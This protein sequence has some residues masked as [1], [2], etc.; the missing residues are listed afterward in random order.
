MP[1]SR[2]RYND[3]VQ[4][5]PEA[6][7][8]YD[9]LI[10]QALNNNDPNR[11][12]HDYIG[13]PTTPTTRIDYDPTRYKQTQ[14]AFSR[15]L[16]VSPS[17]DVNALLYADQGGWEMFGKTV[18]NLL[19]NSVLNMVEQVGSAF[20]FLGGKPDYE[21]AVTKW[22]S[23]KKDALGD[24]YRRDPDAVFD[25]GDPSWWL[26]HGK[27]LTS[28]VIAFGLMGAGV[29]TALAKGAMGFSRLIQGMM[30]ADKAARY[31]SGISRTLQG[32]ANLGSASIL[33]YAEGT[34]SGAETYKKVYD[35]E[36]QRTGDAT[37]AEQVAAR[38]AANTVKI[39]TAMNTALNVTSLAPFFKHGS[40]SDLRRKVG[41]QLFDRKNKGIRLD[42]DDA[43]SPK[44]VPVDGAMRTMVLEER[45]ALKRALGK[46]TLTELKDEIASSPGIK[47][48]VMEYLKR[49]GKKA[50]HESIQEALEELN[51]IWSEKLGEEG[52]GLDYMFRSPGEALAEYWELAKSE[53]GRL[54]MFLGA[55]GGAGQTSFIAAMP[56]TSLQK[57][58][59]TG[60]NRLKISAPKEFQ[61]VR[62]EIS[63]FATTKKAIIDDINDLM[64]AEAMLNQGI[65]EDNSAKIEEAKQQFFNIKARQTVKRGQTDLMI[66]MMEE[67]QGLDNSRPMDESTGESEAKILGFA[68]NNRDNEYIAT[69]QRQI[70][71]LTKLDEAYKQTFDLVNKHDKK[72]PGYSNYVLSTLTDFYSYE[73]LANQKLNESFK[74]LEKALNQLGGL[75]QLES[76]DSKGT[77]NPLKEVVDN[78]RKVLGDNINNQG[79]ITLFTKDNNE[80]I[81]DA[82]DKLKRHKA[83]GILQTPEIKAAFD[84]I[85]ES[86]EFARKS[87]IGYDSYRNAISAEGLKEYKENNSIEEYNKEIEDSIEQELISQGY[88]DEVFDEKFW[89]DLE[90]ET[91][92]TQENAKNGE[93]FVIKIGDN[94]VKIKYE[95]QVDEE[96]NPVLDGENNPVVEPKVVSSVISD[97]SLVPEFT[98]V[99]TKSKGFFRAAKNDDVEYLTAN[100]FDRINAEIIVNREL[101]EISELL[102]KNQKMLEERLAEK[103]ELLNKL[104]EINAEIKE[105]KK[106]FE[107]DSNSKS[108]LSKAR[109]LEL[110]NDLRNRIK[111]LRAS[112]R[113]LNKD[114]KLLEDSKDVML[115]SQATLINELL[116]LKKLGTLDSTLFNRGTEIQQRHNKAV[117]LLQESQQLMTET[118]N[119]IDALNDLRIKIEDAIMTLADLVT[120]LDTISDFNLYVKYLINYR[121]SALS[122][123]NTL[124]R[125][126][127]ESKLKAFENAKNSGN[128]NMTAL[129]LANLINTLS[130]HLAKKGGKELDVLLRRQIELINDEF[131]NVRDKFLKSLTPEER[132]V[133]NNVITDAEEANII[134]YLTTAIPFENTITQLEN[135]LQIIKDT[136]GDRKQ[137]YEQTKKELNTFVDVFLHIQRLRNNLVEE[138]EKI[139]DEQSSEDDIDG[140]DLT[141]EK[142]EETFN[143]RSLN[144][145]IFN[146]TGRD[147]FEDAEGN[148]VQ[149]ENFN[150]L[151]YT[152]LDKNAGSIKKGIAEGKFKLQAFTS[153]NLPENIRKI[154]ESDASFQLQDG[155]IIVMPVSK[156][157]DNN[158]Y[159]VK[160]DSEGNF[161]HP[162]KG[163]E[164]SDATVVFNFMPLVESQLGENYEDFRENPKVTDR[165]IIE[166][167]LQTE[168]GRNNFLVSEDNL[169]EITK[170]RL[171]IQDV[172][173]N[174]TDYEVF[175]QRAYG[176]VKTQFEKSLESIK[177]Q[178]DEAEEGQAVL[179]D[180]VGLTKG[181]IKFKKGD[182]GYKK[183][184]EVI[185]EFLPKDAPLKKDGTKNYK[186]VVGRN[187]STN[188]TLKNN[189]FEIPGNNS[190]QSFLLVDGQTEAI[191]V[192][193]TLIDDSEINTLLALIKAAATKPNEK[194]LTFNT[195]LDADGKVKNISTVNRQITPS[196]GAV[197]TLLDSLISWNS[198]NEKY[199][200]YFD[201]GR[202]KLVFTNPHTQSGMVSVPFSEL[203]AMT[204]DAAQGKF[205][206]NEQIDELVRFLKTKRINV[207]SKLLDETG[208]FYA[209][210]IDAEGNIVLREHSDYTTFLKD[211]LM[212]P[213]IFVT[214]KGKSKHS[215]NLNLGITSEGFINTST[216]T[217]KTG[218]KAA[219][220]SS[221][222]SSEKKTNPRQPFY[223][224]QVVRVKVYNRKTKK[225]KFY[226]AIVVSSGGEYTMVKFKKDGKP[227]KFTNQN[228]YR[229]KYDENVYTKEKERKKSTPKEERNK[230]RKSA[231]PYLKDTIIIHEGEEYRAVKPQTDKV[232]FYPKNFRTEPFSYKDLTKEEEQEIKDKSL[233]VFNDEMLSDYGVAPNNP[234][235]DVEKAEKFKKAREAKE[236]AKSKES[237]TSGQLLQD[238]DFTPL[239]EYSEDSVRASILEEY[240][241]SA[242]IGNI[243]ETF[244]EVMKATANPDLDINNKQAVTSE[245][246][247]PE[248]MRGMI[249]SKGLDKISTFFQPY[250]D[251]GFTAAELL[252]L[253]KIKE[254]K[255][256]T[257]YNPVIEKLTNKL[258]EKNPNRETQPTT[259]TE[260]ET[261]TEESFETSTNPLDNLFGASQ[262]VDLGQ[263]T[264][265][266]SKPPINDEDSNNEITDEEDPNNLC[267]TD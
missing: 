58:E 85:A 205:T 96:G 234:N 88:L 169:K 6:F 199:K 104:K 246:S 159:P 223:K 185:K 209:P 62:D 93:E 177:T 90:S 120:G 12:I 179:L 267:I 106:A 2:F 22:A 144:D 142:M 71:I 190:G 152:Y 97:D 164:Y 187:V 233:T 163:K 127:I 41:K 220:P 217:V 73:E 167:F 202:K 178:I 108:K 100:E 160:V 45:D 222:T 225:N 154:I 238:E 59:K 43:V 36:F 130:Y 203:T 265:P 95:P 81:E 10:N 250:K 241:D 109:F 13:L 53:E 91:G 172:N 188:K 34:L 15:G 113:K 24:V 33:A 138:R 162:S 229:N 126:L 261:S 215:R 161:I 21:N 35:R 77:P 116:F 47:N 105:A 226:T 94:A 174:P 49:T 60:R 115:D 150:E 237:A 65:K 8:E 11:S 228:V 52:R 141:P 83:S 231:I 66:A 148:P 212:M 147:L 189:S 253:F 98:T 92:I 76:F 112:Q 211:K 235:Y 204:Y 124:E 249:V 1:R 248:G 176:I 213:N 175:I 206:G 208:A 166:L 136:I 134:D 14:D 131:E 82:F 51:N 263:K 197:N 25:M 63:E 68:E 221:G 145:Y 102:A 137:M 128:P 196:K 99:S 31:G 255:V 258:F 242:I 129:T 257:N 200:I 23:S 247:F 72:N 9:Q 236:A 133:L 50:S 32:S 198:K 251:S 111:E 64:A 266:L 17:T 39:N 27:D 61:A 48:A 101:A 184:E 219:K 201:F 243:Q 140:V 210:S 3:W 19:S 155:Y 28:S 55:V 118:N 173:G 149:N 107:A 182:I 218:P 153:R 29:S 56:Q 123:F 186:I 232:I 54:S 181:H 259:E 260:E 5:S 216:N 254:E 191:P 80:A 46:R 40:D 214:P 74:L 86:L 157:S 252:L 256:P 170:E 18:G 207:K 230:Q 119:T 79:S 195:A 38:S 192:Q 114:I 20:D 151:W 42:I 78:L 135:E 67:I 57:N 183:G 146:T 70:N 132:Q 224:G 227:V 103:E 125:N 121:E 117:E 84:K 26:N 75:N 110:H 7:N 16:N 37:Y 193:T 69:A 239:A 262:D 156:I 122:E 194:N 139:I 89:Y 244:L 30:S 4:S 44:G 87:R 165:A 240:N 264:T 180:V 245:P 171:P 158:F 168:F 143:D